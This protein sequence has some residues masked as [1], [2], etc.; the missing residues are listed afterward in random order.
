M[1][2]PFTS[3]LNAAVPVRWSARRLRDALAGIRRDEDG[4]IAVE[5]ALVAL[6]LG[7]LMLGAFNFGT[8][9]LHKMEMANAVRAGLQYAVVRKPIQG[10]TSQIS[11]TVLNAAP[12]DKLGT[13]SLTVAV[14]CQ[15]PDSSSVACG[16][17]C[18]SGDPRT[19]VSIQMQED[20]DTL[21]KMPGIDQRLSFQT[22][23]SVRLN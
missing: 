22:S 13:R 4:A 9:A 3:H 11:T 19:F 17:T 6:F 12:A 8:A 1:Q 16:G 5:W 18:S 21:V 23:G 2:T 15:C 7:F 14:F 20:Y 10:D